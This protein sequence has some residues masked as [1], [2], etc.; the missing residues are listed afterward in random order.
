MVVLRQRSIAASLFCASAT[1]T[2]IDRLAI[3]M[4]RVVVPCG[5]ARSKA[6]TGLNAYKKNYIDTGSAQPIYDVLIYGFVFAYVVAWPQVRAH[7]CPTLC[8]L[9]LFLPSSMILPRNGTGEPHASP[10][11][12]IV[13]FAQHMVA[14]VVTRFRSG[15]KKITSSL[16]PQ[17]P[18][19]CNA[20]TTLPDGMTPCEA[21]RTC[22]LVPHTLWLYYA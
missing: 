2:M 1:H 21:V 19:C 4:L 3:C 5:R 13:G 9:R 14:C 8:A 16:L 15:D 12:A 11:N 20:H 17:L 7:A 10:G 6:E 22:Q 18:H